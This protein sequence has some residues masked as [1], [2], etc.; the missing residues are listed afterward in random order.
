MVP[1]TRL[2]GEADRGRERPLGRTRKR[3]KRGG[4]PPVFTFEAAAGAPLVSTLRFGRELAASGGL[5]GAHSHD[6]LALAYFERDGESLR[7]GNQ[8]W[9]LRAGDVFVSPP[10]EIHDPSGLADAEG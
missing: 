5:P 3:G 8:W 7:L 6:Y 2:G 4:D 10:G 1:R 9:E